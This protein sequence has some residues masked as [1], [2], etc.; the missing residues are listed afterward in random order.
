MENTKQGTGQQEVQL[1]AFKLEGEEYAVDILSVQEIIRWTQ[2][3]RVPKAPVF[4]KGVI[5]LRGT[6]IPIVDSRERFGLPDQEVTDTT[7]IIVCRLED[8]PI[9]LTVDCVTE[10]LRISNEQIEKPQVVNGI[11]N[12]YI[13]GIGKIDGRL[14][15]ILDLTRVLDIDLHKA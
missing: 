6:V 5:N 14:L 11:D 2:I 15:I 1:V 7:R 8:A 9:G 13:K 4:V 10:V 3:T 12:Q